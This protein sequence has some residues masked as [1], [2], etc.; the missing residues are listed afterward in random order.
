[1]VAMMTVGAGEG[2]WIGLNDRAIEAGCDGS[3]FVWIDC[4]PNDFDNRADGK[5][6]CGGG[7]AGIGSEG[8]KYGDE[9]CCEL[10][11]DCKWNEA[12]CA[13]LR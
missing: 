7:T 1:M 3:A 4:A 2:T 9:D 8:E 6:H 12:K 13:S 5:A 11:A 10:H